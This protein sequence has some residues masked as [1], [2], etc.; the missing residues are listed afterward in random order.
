[1]GVQDLVA[2]NVLRVERVAMG[3]LLDVSLDAQIHVKLD[4][5]IVVSEAVMRLALLIL[6]G[7]RHKRNKNRSLR[8]PIFFGQNTYI[9]LVKKSNKMIEV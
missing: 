2:T 3:V 1:M 4:A 8:T 9:L 7:L 5:E 6:P